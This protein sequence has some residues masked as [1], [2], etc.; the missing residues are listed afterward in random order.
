[1]KLTSPLGGIQQT[2]ASETDAKSVTLCFGYW[3]ERTPPH[4][5]WYLTWIITLQHQGRTCQ[6]NLQP[7][8]NWQHLLI[9]SFDT[10]EGACGRRED[11]CSNTSSVNPL[12][13]SKTRMFSEQM[14]AF[15][16]SR[17]LEIY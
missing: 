15:I 1:M 6:S 10:F 7:T 12:R 5:P 3:E 2:G 4:P 9:H 14:V 17:N 13:Q 16:Q 11:Q 8:A